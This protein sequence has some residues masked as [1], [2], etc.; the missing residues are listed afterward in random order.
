[1][2][3]YAGVYD[4]ELRVAAGADDGTFHFEVNG[5]DVSQPVVRGEFGWLGKAGPPFWSKM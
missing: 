2:L 4:V 5:A 1:M 3:T